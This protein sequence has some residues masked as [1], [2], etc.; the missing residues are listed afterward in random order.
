VNATLRGLAGASLWAL[1]A[2]E[3]AAGVPL[4]RPPGSQAIVSDAELGRIRDL[5]MPL[6]GGDQ[7]PDISGTYAL[8]SG[9]YVAATDPSQLGQ[10]TCRARTTYSARPDGTLDLD[11]AYLDCPGAGTTHGVF[12]SGRGAC[13]SLYARNQQ[14]FEACALTFVTVTSACV[15]DAGLVDFQYAFL[16]QAQTG[17][18]CAGLVTAGRVPQPGSI[19]VISETDGL[20]ARVR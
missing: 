3:G 1:L 15:S 5:G 9:R 17:A 19:A 10:A 12:I 16:A 18:T 6:H 2:C 8:D 4:V 13:F 7:P 20:L 11:Y 14:D